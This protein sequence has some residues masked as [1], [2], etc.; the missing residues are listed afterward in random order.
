MTTS[1]PAA[2]PAS[3]SS[4]APAIPW[5]DRPAGSTSVLWRSARN[6]IIRRDHLPRSNSIFNSAV[7][8]F[9]EGFAGVFR[10]DDTTRTMNLHAGRSADG[11]S[12]RISPEPIL[13]GAAD[14]RVAEI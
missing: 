2:N 14:E 4:P 10:V 3:P 11:V 7:V 8:P 1:R 5:E 12:W 9:G 6:P 13:F